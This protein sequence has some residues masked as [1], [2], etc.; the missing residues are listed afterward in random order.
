MI[1]IGSS[2]KI[3]R[4]TSVTCIGSIVVI[5]VVAGR[6]VIGYGYMGPFDDVILVVD[7]KGG[8]TPARIGGMAGGTV[9]TD[10]YGIMVRVGR[11]VI[12]RLVTAH[13]F[14]WGVVIIS[15]M[16]GRTV[17]ADALMSSCQWPEYGMVKGNRSPAILIMTHDTIGREILGFMVR[18]DRCIKIRSMASVTC[19]G[20]IVV[21]AVVTRDTLV[22]Y[23]HVS[24]CYDIIIVVV[25]K[26][27]GTP[28]RI[29]GMATV[30]LR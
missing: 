15:I 9:G 27:G 29:S 30:A 10:A 24:P 16:A 25:G 6:T 14:R 8:G 7:A 17:I 2:V 13:A 11:L 18:I 5:P 28:A 21:I 12:I 4:M 3:C 1:R 19:I 26:G 23:G 20:C 22:C